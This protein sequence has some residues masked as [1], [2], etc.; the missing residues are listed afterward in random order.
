MKHK[1]DYHNS[2]KVPISVMGHVGVLK[3]INPKVLIFMLCLT[4]TNLSVPVSENVSSQF[5]K[6]IGFKIVLDSRY[7]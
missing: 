1:A 2:M 6:H 5:E 3:V 7:T 4:W